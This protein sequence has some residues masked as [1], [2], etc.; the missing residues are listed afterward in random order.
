MGNPI[1]IFISFQPI[2]FFF[3]LLCLFST[4]WYFHFIAFT[5]LLEE[6][7]IL[8]YPQARA[9]RRDNSAKIDIPIVNLV[10]QV[11]DMLDNIQQNLFDVAKQKRDAC[12]KTVR[13]WD[14]F[15]EALG[16]KKM[17]LA[18]WCDEMVWKLIPHVL[19][20]VVLVDTYHLIITCFLFNIMTLPLPLSSILYCHIPQHFYTWFKMSV[21]F[22]DA[23]DPGL[24]Y[25]EDN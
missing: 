17:I 25:K 15:I 5:Y 2:C 3:I 9:V 21:H 18:P 7:Y 22:W 24:G 23:K 12:I 20:W 13:T 6:W 11:K 19:L 4:L 14:E 16:Q 10:E 8:F 1:A